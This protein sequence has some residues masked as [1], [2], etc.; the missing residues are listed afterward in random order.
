MKI[1]AHALL[2][3]LL[4]LGRCQPDHL[5]CGLL[6]RTTGNDGPHRCFCQEGNW[7]DGLNCQID[8]SLYTGSNGSA[9]SLV[10][11]FCT[12]GLQWS[13]VGCEVVNTL[14][15]AAEV[16]GAFDCSAIAHTLSP[17]AQMGDDN[18]QFPISI[19][20]TIKRNV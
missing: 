20:F 10:S 1:S 15:G 17:L 8:C 18:L 4:V 3:A 2:A 11:C 7:W 9:S 5:D 14:S 19:P 12:E 13:S 16:P 6:E